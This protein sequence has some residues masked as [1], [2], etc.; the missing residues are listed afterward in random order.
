MKGQ[1]KTLWQVLIAMVLGMVIGAS[2]GME[3]SI[4]GI[5][6]YTIY[7][8]LGQLFINGLMMVVI[9]LVCAS[10]IVSIAKIGGDS[11]FGRIGL[12]TILVFLGLNFIAILVGL[13]IATILGPVIQKSALEMSAMNTVQSFVSSNNVAAFDQGG[14]FWQIILQIIPPNIFEALAKGQILGLIFFSIIFGFV[15]TKIEKDLSNLLKHFWEAIFQCMIKI[16]HLIMKVLPVGVFFLVAKQFAATGWTAFHSLGLFLLV[17]LLALA[18]YAL[19]VLPLFLKFIAKVSPWAHIKAMSSALIT[20]FSTS[21][22][23]ATLP[24][25]MDCVEKKIG[26]SNKICS[27]VIP[28]GTTLNMSGTALYSYLAALFVAFAYGIDMPFTTKLLMAFLSLLASIGIAGV[29]SASIIT[30]VIILRSINVPIDGI[31]LF[32]AVDRILDMFRT[33]ANV[34]S[35]SASAVAIASLEGEKLFKGENNALL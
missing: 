22:S 20:A 17:V 11:S 31:A 6:I 24:I 7:S 27:L 30:V 15:I 34:L 19:I 23:A 35:D 14:G 33:T 13:L 25:T 9:P 10:L 8:I 26:V 18:I 5:Q 32:L 4:F 28:L 1:K 16:T 3:G 29:P 2:T 21:S 12:K